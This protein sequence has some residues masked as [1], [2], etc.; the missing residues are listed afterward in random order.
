M[1]MKMAHS[2]II[3]FSTCFKPLINLVNIALY[4]NHFLIFVI[5]YMLYSSGSLS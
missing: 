1:G 4:D 3:R 2:V 5:F